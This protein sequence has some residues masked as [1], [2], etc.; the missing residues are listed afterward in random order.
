MKIVETFQYTEDDGF[1]K[2]T[3]NIMYN[4]PECCTMCNTKLTPIRIGYSIYSSAKAPHM[5]HLLITY[6]CNKC[7]NATMCDYK[8]CPNENWVAIYDYAAPEWIGILNNSGPKQ[9]N[10]RDFDDIIQEISPKFVEI[11]NQAL[12]SETYGLAELSGIGYRRAF[13]FLIKDYLIY[14]DPDNKD[15]I[16]SSSLQNCIHNRP[17]I[18]P[19]VQK[20]AE[21]TVW[22]GNDFAH[23]TKKYT[24]SDL[25]DLKRCID[26][27]VYMICMHITTE[28]TK[29][30]LSQQL[31][32]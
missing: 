9:P 17:E 27:A 2:N 30:T 10:Q 25:S 13:E 32:K 6:H 3:L 8:I 11:Y 16:K 19:M 26:A 22:L 12:A 15:K 29:D 20:I 1:S 24:D 5:K 7:D 14:L 4:A 31:Q 21:P 23:Y 18:D 28:A